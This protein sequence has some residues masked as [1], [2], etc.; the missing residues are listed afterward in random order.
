MPAYFWVKNIEFRPVEPV[1]WSWDFGDGGTSTERNPLHV[2][3]E[4]GLYTVGLEVNDGVAS[5]IKPNY[6][7]V[8]GGPTPPSPPQTEDLGMPLPTLPISSLINVQVNLSPVAAAIQNLSTLLIL[9]NSPVIDP[10]E[11]YRTYTDISSVA[12]DFGTS[13]PEYLAAVLWF[14][15]VPQPSALL[16]GRWVRTASSGGVKGGTLSLASQLMANFTGIADGKFTYTKDGGSPITTGNINLT[17]AANLPAVAAAITAQ[18]AGVTFTWNSVFQRFEAV[19]AVT[20]ATSAVSFLTTPGSGT[21]ISGLLGM[22]ADQSGAYLIPGDDPETAAQCAA[23]FDLNYGQKWYGLFMIAATDGDHLAVAPLISAMTNKHVYFVSTQEAGSITAASTTDIGYLLKQAN[24]R[25]VFVQYSSSNPYAV[26]SAAAR[27]LTTDYAGNSTVITLM[28]K[29]EP[30]IVAEFLNTTQAGAA[31]AKNINLFAE[32]NNDTAIILYGTCADGTFLDTLIGCDW[33]SLECEGELYNL[34]YTSPTK[35][36]QT[37][38]GMQMLVAVIESVCAQGVINGLLAPGTW[39]T[40]GFGQL[41]R[42]DFLPKG[43][44]VYAPLVASQS[45]A[46]RAA[47]KAVSIQVAAKLAGAVHTLAMTINVNQ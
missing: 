39:T 40:N 27:I 11:R 4:P 24:I 26:V 16:I 44:Y 36:P 25:R 47:R 34:L 35:I 20:G 19:S 14:E 23:F 18:T 10:V 6:V 28:Y 43:F 32:F 8:L 3:V 37:D 7:L 21:D 42:G 5:E 45:A 1:A 17:G 41:A 22:R 30:G 13:A 46:D 38:A 33:L 15:Q 2:Y 12:A 29:Q 9:G 31:K